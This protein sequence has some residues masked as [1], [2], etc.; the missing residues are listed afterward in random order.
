MIAGKK[1]LT[2]IAVIGSFLLGSFVTYIGLQKDTDTTVLDTEQVTVEYIKVNDEL[3]DLLVTPK[4]GMNLTPEYSLNSKYNYT[5]AYLVGM[6]EEK[7]KQLYSNREHP[8]YPFTWDN[9][10]LPLETVADIN[11]VVTNDSEFSVT[12]DLPDNKTEFTAYDITVN[13]SKAVID[14]MAE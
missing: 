5:D 11:T 4:N 6:T 7:A 1:V 12:V 10:S 2:V 14:F 8:A 3:F 13:G 9:S